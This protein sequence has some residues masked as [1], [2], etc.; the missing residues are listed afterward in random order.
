[1][2]SKALGTAITSRLNQR[3]V[4]TLSV[5][6]LAVDEYAH[7]PMADLAQAP[8]VVRISVCMAVSKTSPYD[9][10]YSAD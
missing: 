10:L 2:V 8:I 4:S 1:M 5:E 7:C 9:H 6:E 3:C